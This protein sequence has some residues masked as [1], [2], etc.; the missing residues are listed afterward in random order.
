MFF[1][2]T[3]RY[4][5]PNDSL[6]GINKL[7]QSHKYFLEAPEIIFNSAVAEDQKP[8]DRNKIADR[9]CFLKNCLKFKKQLDGSI[10]NLLELPNELLSLSFEEGSAYLGADVL[11]LLS[12]HLRLLT[13]KSERDLRSSSQTFV[14]AFKDWLRNEMA[15]L[16]NEVKNIKLPTHINELTK[17]HFLLFSFNQRLSETLLGDAYDCSEIKEDFSKLLLKLALAYISMIPQV[18]DLRALPAYDFLCAYPGAQLFRLNLNVDSAESVNLLTQREEFLIAWLDV[19]EGK[20]NKTDNKDELKKNLMWMFA[21]AYSD[22]V[23]RQEVKLLATKG[24]AI[25][26]ER[27]YRIHHYFESLRAECV[28]E[29]KQADD[30][31]FLEVMLQEDKYADFSF[32]LTE[33]CCGNVSPKDFNERDIYSR[34]FLDAFQKQ[35]PDFFKQYQSE[36]LR[37]SLEKKMRHF[38]LL[39]HKLILMSLLES[40]SVSNSIE[41]WLVN[42]ANEVNKEL[43]K[44]LMTEAIKLEEETIIPHLAIRLALGKR[45]LKEQSDE[46]LLKSNPLLL[47]CYSPNF[48]KVKF[49]SKTLKIIYHVQ[50]QILF[51]SENG[52]IRE[53]A[54]IFCRDYRI[55]ME[56]RVDEKLNAMSS[57]G[58]LE[59]RIVTEK[60]LRHK[61]R[62]ELGNLLCR[63][64]LGAVN[65][66]RQSQAQHQDWLG[67]IGG[68][69]YYDDNC[70]LNE[71]EGLNALPYSSILQQQAFFVQ[72]PI[73]SIN[74]R[75]T[76]LRELIIFNGFLS[77]ERNPSLPND[78]LRTPD[79]E[80]LERFYG[81]ALN[82]QKQKSR[83]FF[84]EGMKFYLEE[85]LVAVKELVDSK[86][87]EVNFDYFFLR[88][89]TW[90]YDFSNKQAL[91]DLV[92]NPDLLEKHWRFN[93]LE[94]ELSKTVAEA[95][96]AVLKVAKQWSINLFLNAFNLKNLVALSSFEINLEKWLALPNALERQACL[97]WY[98]SDDQLKE[99]QA[100][101]LEDLSQW[102]A[103][104]V[105]ELI[106]ALKIE[107]EENIFIDHF[108]EKYTALLEL[109]LPL[110]AFLLTAEEQMQLADAHLLLALYT[111]RKKNHQEFVQS[112]ELIQLTKAEKNKQSAKKNHYINFHKNRFER[113][114]VLCARAAQQKPIKVLS[115][116]RQEGAQLFAISEGTLAEKARRLVENSEV[117]FKA[118]VK[119]QKE[120]GRN[121]LDWVKDTDRAGYDFIVE[122]YARQQHL[123]QRYREIQNCLKNLEGYQSWRQQFSDST[124]SE[125][126]SIA[127]KN[128]YQQVN[129]VLRR[130]CSVWGELFFS[131][132]QPL[133]SSEEFC[134]EE[135][136]A[137]LDDFSENQLRIEFSQIMN[138]YEVAFADSNRLNA[139]FKTVMATQ[140]SQ[141]DDDFLTTY[142]AD[143]SAELMRSFIKKYLPQDLAEHLEKMILGEVV[144]LVLQELIKIESWIRG[145]SSINDQ[146]L[147]QLIKQYQ[148]IAS[149]ALAGLEAVYQKACVK[150]NQEEEV[151][152]GILNSAKIQKDESCGLS[153]GLTLSQ[154][155]EQQLAARRRSSGTNNSASP[156]SRRS[157][158]SLVA[159]PK[160]STI[161]CDLL[162]P[163]N[164]N[165]EE[166]KKRFERLIQIFYG[167]PKIELAESAVLLQEPTLRP[168]AICLHQLID[169]N[170][171]SHNKKIPDHSLED[172]LTQLPLAKLSEDSRY[173]HAGICKSVAYDEKEAQ[174]QEILE[175]I[176]QVNAFL[177]T[178]VTGELKTMSDFAR[179]RLQHG[180]FMRRLPIAPSYPVKLEQDRKDPSCGD[181]SLNDALIRFWKKENACFQVEDLEQIILSSDN[182]ADGNDDLVDNNV[183]PLELLDSGVVFRMREILDTQVLTQVSLAITSKENCARRDELYAAIDAVLK[184]AFS[185]PATRELEERVAKITTDYKDVF[186]W[187]KIASGEQANGVKPR[188]A[189]QFQAIQEIIFQANDLLE[190][191]QGYLC[192]KLEENKE[193]NRNEQTLALKNLLASLKLKQV[194]FDAAWSKLNT[195]AREGSYMS[196]AVEEEPKSTGDYLIVLSSSAP[197]ASMLCATSPLSKTN[198][199]LNRTSARNTKLFEWDNPEGPNDDIK[200]ANHCSLRN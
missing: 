156:A 16:E 198:M 40:D 45:F 31:W 128:E 159:T 86:E 70:A 60:M 134:G 7:S 103:Q 192:L 110:T 17:R 22:P 65:A 194:E 99:K 189:R 37:L 64:S 8:Y 130:L 25:Y 149:K 190:S 162:S 1:Q 39:G 34:F 63:A 153:L 51:F 15:A 72:Q 117:H 129:R 136:Q 200:R 144:H 73:K 171:R 142:R 87:D 186:N 20:F 98:F 143:N 77:G 54:G 94:R 33:Y 28:P 59:E 26:Q 82:G 102:A 155:H 138:D 46:L 182:F 91:L 160:I 157:S 78:F 38:P 124:L 85:F 197:R 100:A 135:Y 178:E 13:N 126:E 66:G 109:S 132:F 151:Y 62:V 58:K 89:S 191:L 93:T 14:D 183:T 79:S 2:L 9:R 113:L 97:N 18:G 41:H 104:N 52:K 24:K 150:P 107:E 67:I 158:N 175:F 114:L 181:S 108:S 43:A 111:P 4:E 47:F 101:F 36:I 105:R 174:Q 53:K 123:L 167:D 23:T 44:L 193:K 10:D 92:F 71:K 61:K 55:N 96:E 57:A 179:F 106:N 145:D 76:L 172:F 140:L 199:G 195:K 152:K 32:A 147:P 137:M 56:G 42:I 121:G 75:I 127:D 176:K 27:Y 81:E 131:I 154:K 88:Y 165:D 50:L 115:I 19:V 122:S 170:W 74:L 146:N 112:F 169:A 84:Q 185:N 120:G 148:P 35:P 196:I 168:I 173:Y 3:D 188:G 83:R 177:T 80:S 48:H 184:E 49:S 68:L 125:N 166:S 21:S 139:T 69:I 95:K 163:L 12:L 141:A 90:P 180:K 5:K 164:N 116:A 119:N 118:L 187:L 30:N 29:L 6:E 161:A 11:S 133:F